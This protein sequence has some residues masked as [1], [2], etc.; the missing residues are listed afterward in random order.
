MRSS[1]RINYLL[2][3]AVPTLV[4]LSA[5][6]PKKPSGPYDRVDMKAF[7]KS[8][9][10]QADVIWGNSGTEWDTDGE[11]ELF[12]TTDAGWDELTKAGRELVTLGKSLGGK[13]NESD[14]RAEAWKAYAAGFSEVSQKLVVA[15]EQH[16]KENIFAEGGVLYQ[17]CTACHGV[18][19]APE[20]ADA[21]A[22]K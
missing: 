22:P 9:D 14:P 13:I 7:M 12:P 21:A 5:C 17:V 11:K 15:A 4:T 19:P 20:E 1:A 16:D 10:T 6:G 8:V 2:L 18:F 3:L